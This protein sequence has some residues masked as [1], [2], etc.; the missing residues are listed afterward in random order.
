MLDATRMVFSDLRYAALAAAIL[1]GLMFILLLLSGF[2]FLEPYPVAHIPL[3]GELGLVL[4]VAMSAISAV[5]IPM[6]VYLVGALRGSQKRLTGGVA[7]SI[8]GTA[9]GACSCGPV[10]LALVTTFGGVG[11]AASSF[12]ANY[13]IPLRAAAVALLLAT[14]YLTARSIGAECRLRG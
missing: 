9:V 11:A 10:G 6:N 5:V 7:G 4:I 1:S 13:E 8:I 2:V 12:V 14:Y 3:D